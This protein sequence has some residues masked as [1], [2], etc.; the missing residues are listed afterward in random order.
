M[1][2]TTLPR[3]G[4]PDGKS[5]VLL[6]KNSLVGYS[7]WALHRNTAIYGADADDFR[8]QRWESLRVGW[9]YIPFNGGPRICLGQQYALTEASYVIIRLLQTFKDLD[10]RDPVL[11]F[12]EALTLTLASA[13]GTKV[14]LTPA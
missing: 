8:P 13:T 10:N 5:K 12:K 9:E 14:A 2:V 4:G 3:G 7:A 11:E 1:Q 6:P